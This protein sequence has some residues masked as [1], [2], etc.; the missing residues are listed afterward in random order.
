MSKLIKNILGGYKGAHK[1]LKNFYLFIRDKQPG[2]YSESL[3]SLLEEGERGAY[4]LEFKDEN[5]RE[6]Y[7]FD[8]QMEAEIVRFL[9]QLATNKEVNLYAVEKK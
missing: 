7:K 9:Y 6:V 2:N 5:K 1:A 8:K 4:F 3:E